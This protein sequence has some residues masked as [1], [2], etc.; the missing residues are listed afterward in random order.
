LVSNNIGKVFQLARNLLP[1]DFS[2]LK[3]NSSRR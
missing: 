2:A 1:L 3:K